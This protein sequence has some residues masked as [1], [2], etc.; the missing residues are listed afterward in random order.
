MVLEHLVGT[1]LEAWAP[2]KSV[3]PKDD[4]DDTTSP[5]AGMQRGSGTSMENGG[6]TLME[7]G[8]GLV[9]GRR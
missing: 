5:Q 7:N 8:N 2:V 3:R 1:L 6:A 9:V 4:N